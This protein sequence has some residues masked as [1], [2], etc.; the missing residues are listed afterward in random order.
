MAVV[1]L[2]RILPALDFSPEI[3]YNSGEKF[4]QRVIICVLLIIPS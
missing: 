2:N 4:F 3:G 1:F